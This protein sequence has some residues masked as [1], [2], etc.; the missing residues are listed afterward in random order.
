M[1]QKGGVINLES[2]CVMVKLDL[3]C[4]TITQQEFFIRNAHGHC[5]CFL[6]LSCSEGLGSLYSAN[7]GNG[8]QILSAFSKIAMKWNS[9]LFILLF[10]DH[11]DY[12]LDRICCLYMDP[13]GSFCIV[14]IETLLLSEFE[15][16]KPHS[17]QSIVFC[18]LEG[19][20]LSKQCCC[21]Q[22]MILTSAIAIN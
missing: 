21:L 22:N 1:F 7:V 19:G 8:E 14:Y 13:G 5:G 3:I 11:G 6:S 16:F 15:P 12:L 10:W 4:S 18:I 17:S 20:H 9:W 2:C